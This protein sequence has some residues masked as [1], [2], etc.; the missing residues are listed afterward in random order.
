LVLD[1]NGEFLEHLGAFQDTT[2][3]KL[4]IPDVPTELKLIQQEYELALLVA[5]TYEP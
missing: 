3:I 2:G 5:Y 4:N 1:G